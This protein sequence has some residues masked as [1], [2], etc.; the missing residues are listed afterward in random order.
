MTTILSM[1]DAKASFTEVVKPSYD[2]FID[3]Q[4][5]F[6]TAFNAATAL[7]QMHEWVY[8]F[9]R[10]DLEKKY[11]TT[12]NS[13]GEFWGFVETLSLGGKYIRDLANASK[14]V[15]LTIRPSTSMTHIENTVIQIVG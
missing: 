8:E 3:T 14:H 10:S 11:S 13:K 9:N 15:R 6:R 4:S 1:D 2:E 7:F 5:T 12:F